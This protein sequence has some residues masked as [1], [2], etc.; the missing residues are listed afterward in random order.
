[1]LG[2]VFELSSE[3]AGAVLEISAAAYRKRL[4]RAREKLRA[5]MRGHCGLVN[6]DRPCRCERRVVH[7]VAIG[8]VRPDALLFANGSNDGR[9][10]P[11]VAQGVGEMEELHRIAGIY[12]SHPDYATPERV[13]S[14]IRKIVDLDRLQ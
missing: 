5:F 9:K 7:A 11:D 13:L 12:Q 4:S 2:E 10:E 1:V 3:E 14:G 6:A 8:L